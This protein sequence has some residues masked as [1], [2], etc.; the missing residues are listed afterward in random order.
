VKESGSRTGISRLTRHDVR[1]AGSKG[2][3]G[4]CRWAKGTT[5]YDV[6]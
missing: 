3:A 4:P 1:G 5:L 2:Q 6:K